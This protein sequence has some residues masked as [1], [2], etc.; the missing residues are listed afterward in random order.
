MRDVEGE[1][2]HVGILCC[3]LCCVL[4]EERK[5]IRKK[6]SCTYHCVVVLCGEVV[7]LLGGERDDEGEEKLHVGVVCCCVSWLGCE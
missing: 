1:G 5:M 3:V 6:E 7:R 4:S 2:E